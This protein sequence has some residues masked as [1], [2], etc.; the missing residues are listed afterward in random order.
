MMRLALLAAACCAAAAAVSHAP[1]QVLLAADAVQFEGL[2]AALGSLDAVGGVAATVVTPAGDVAAAERLA[3]CAAPGLATRVVAVEAT[4]AVRLNATV[5]A[6]PAAGEQ[7]GNL[8]SL[9]NYAR[10]YAP[11]I[12]PPGTRMALYVDADVVVRCSVRAL[13]E[14][15]RANATRGAPFFAV[16]RGTCLGNAALCARCP[17]G[18]GSFNAGV[19][20]YDLRAWHRRNATARLEA[21]MR[22]AAAAVARGDPRAKWAQPSSQDPMVDVFCGDYGALPPSWNVLFT[23]THRA[24]PKHL[25]KY[26]PRPLDAPAAAERNDCAWHF[27]GHPKPWEDDP[28]PWFADLFRP[29]ARPCCA[30]PR[31]DRCKAWRAQDRG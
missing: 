28:T 10:F 13:L 17:R 18:R 23:H 4:P 2:A 15:A 7:Y 24:A 9:E 31:S 12:L 5:A 19:V 22:D 20:A 3:A 14:A 11:A 30:D 25:R 16:D 1:A 27:K 6:F 21:A 26:V 29:Y 8:G